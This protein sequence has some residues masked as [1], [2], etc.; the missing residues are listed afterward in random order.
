[1]KM[2]S[3]KPVQKGGNK[4][5]IICKYFILGKCIKGENCPYLH[6]Q[7]EKPKEMSE[8]ECPMYSIGFCKNGPVCH[9]LHIK[10]DKYVEE[11]LEEKNTTSTTPKAEEQNNINIINNNDNN[12]N[13]INNTNENNNLN[14]AKNDEEKEINDNKEDNINYP[15]IPIWYLEHYYNKPLS[16]IF[17]ELEQKNLFACDAAYE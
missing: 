15:E 12:I 5:K 14:N 16:M 9:F 6:S 11:D 13:N 1:M 3:L 7:V 8:V 10:K 4:S 2:S 17:S